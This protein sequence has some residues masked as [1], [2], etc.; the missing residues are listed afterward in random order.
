M[1]KKLLQA[2][3]WMDIVEIVEASNDLFDAEI[4]QQRNPNETYPDTESFYKGVLQRLRKSNDCPPPIE[5]RY[6]V[7]L[8]AAE[9]ATGWKLSDLRTSENTLIRLF[10]AH[11]LHNE[12]YSYSQIGR[13]MKRDHSSITH[14]YKRVEEMMSVPFAF[15][16]ELKLYEKFNELL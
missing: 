8:D 6:P 16:E 14:M 1:K 3:T 9:Q 2:L 11:R 5:E 10:V 15:K 4:Y 12:G 7:V 13:Q